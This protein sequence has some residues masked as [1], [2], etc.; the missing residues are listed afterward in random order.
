MDERLTLAELKTRWQATL[1]AT[2]LSTTRHPCDYKALKSLA[3]EV[4]D[5][6]IDIDSY[7]PTVKKLLDH[8]ERLDPMGRGSLFHI[9]RERIKPESIWHVRL[10]RMECL[11]L[12]AHI[13]AFEKWRQG[14]HGLRI[15]K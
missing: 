9:F 5:A 3:A 6:P 8:L 2:R 10:L 11:D 13:D 15:V 12:L 4:V 1:Q 7:F 14:Q